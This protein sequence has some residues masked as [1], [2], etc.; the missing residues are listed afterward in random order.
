[1]QYLPEGVELKTPLKERDVRRLRSGDI[2]YFTGFIWT[3]MHGPMIRAI[4]EGKNPPIDTKQY[5]VF[6]V[7]RGGKEV[8]G[9]FEC[10]EINAPV[11]TTGFRY[12]KWIPDMIRRFQLL[13]IIA[14]DG[15]GLHTPTIEACKEVGCITGAN[16]VFPPKQRVTKTCK[17]VKEAFWLDVKGSFV[18][19]VEYMGPYVVNIDSQG[20]CH[21][22]NRIE[23]TMRRATK[24]YE[25]LKISDFQYIPLEYF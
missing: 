2:I 8:N 16:Y 17:G 4:E 5:N 18:V 20:N 23:D 3:G 1:M 6:A 21:T 22:K 19:E 9:N 12:I 11:P 10:S 13:A 14:K 25:K 24:V 15:M 7:G